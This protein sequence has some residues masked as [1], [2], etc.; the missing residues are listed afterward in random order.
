ME[1][2]ENYTDTFA[3]KGGSVEII[4]LD[5]H[6]ADSEHPFAIRKIIPFAK[7]SPIGNNFTKRQ[8]ML[9]S[10]AKEYKWSYAAQKNTKTKFLRNFIFFRTR[11]IPYLYN[12]LTGPD[13]KFRV[14]DVDFTE[15][16]F[17]ARE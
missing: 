17:I 13:K 1:G 2:L 8:T 14:F 11:Q 15:G 3:I 10:V 4:G 12:T 7:L 16:A 6:G 9:K 5:K